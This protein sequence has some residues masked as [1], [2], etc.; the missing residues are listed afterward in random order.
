VVTD[1]D[2]ELRP[3][4]RVALVGPS[5]SGKSTVAALL[6]R[7][8][9]PCAGRITLNDID[10]REFALADLRQVIGLVTEDA[11]LFDT[12]IEENLRI[13]RPDATPAQMRDAL[14][15]ARLLDWVQTL[16]NGLQTLV[17]ER[18]TKLS[19]GQRRRLAL[20]RALLADFPVL[21]LDEP[22]EHLDDETAQAVTTDLLEA[23]R[24]RA[25]LLITHQPFGL[26][27]VDEV[28]RLGAE[29]SAWPAVAAR[30]VVAVRR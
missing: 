5:G 6:V 2:F 4:R 21:V 14:R 12:T 20:A 30:E 16:P 18:G 9:D 19:G 29:D 28:V 27:Q 1:I 26:D 3:G 17:G 10:I 25:V 11:H 23:T 15:Q 8:L 13:A 22:T 7:F 24:D